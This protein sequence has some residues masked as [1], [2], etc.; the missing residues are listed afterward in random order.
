MSEVSFEKVLRGVDATYV[1]GLTATPTRKD[2]LHKIVAMQCGEIC[3][4][5]TAKSQS[6]LHPFDHVLIPRFTNFKITTTTFR[7]F[8]RIW[9]LMNNETR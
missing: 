7:G 4:K 5:M 2:G 3:Y 9:L 6:K 1:H 8:M